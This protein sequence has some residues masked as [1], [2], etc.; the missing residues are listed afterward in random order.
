MTDKALGGL[1]GIQKEGCDGIIT[2]ATFILH[3][4]PPAVR[5]VCLE[6]FGQVR[7]A[8]PC[9]VEIRRYLDAQPGGARLAG[10][11]HLD[12]RYVKAV[13]YATKARRPGRPKM[14]L[15]GDIV[16]EDEDAVAAAASH[17]V[18]LANARHAEGFI[19]VAPDMRKKFWLDR[20]RTAAI[21]KHTNAF[22][23]N[24]DVVIPIEGLGGYSDGIEH[25]N[26]ELSISNKLKLVDALR[27][28]PA[29]RSP[30]RAARGSRI[31]RPSSSPIASS[32]RKTLVA[33]TRR[34]LAAGCSTTSTR[35]SPRSRR[36]RRPP[37]RPR[38]RRR[39]PAP[40]T[41]TLFHLL[42]DYTIRVSWKTELCAQLGDIFDGRPFVPIVK[43]IEATHKRGAARPRVR[44]AAHARGRRQR[45]HQHPGQLRQLRDAAGGGRSGRAHHEARGRR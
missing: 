13:G 25:I 45:A 29:R 37:T 35:R 17:V 36:A 3:R 39:S 33:E 5:T 14:V 23:I 15:I 18:R 2:Q 40:R 38:S 4:M 22:K 43:A 8:V 12:E 31:G 30:A 32:S 27:N 10:L 44:G 41:T 7:E 19:A 20:A 1:P 21:S 11:E 9:I 34:A 42:Q 28:A 16:G 6:F 26:I 24:E